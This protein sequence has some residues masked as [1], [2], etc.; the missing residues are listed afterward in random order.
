MP[1]CHIIY[2]WTELYTTVNNWRANSNKKITS[3]KK[4]LKALNT[5]SCSKDA[6]LLTI[7]PELQTLIL[8][9]HNKLRNDTALGTVDGLP[10]AKRMAYMVY[11]SSNYN[12]ALC[13]L[14]FKIGLMVASCHRLAMGHWTFLRSRMQCRRM[15]IRP[16]CLQ[17]DR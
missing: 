10:S 8:D 7:T 2:N 9:L 6:A 16:R 3:K 17:H 14:S 15:Q 13:K 1:Q 12:N 4:K 11:N 5:T